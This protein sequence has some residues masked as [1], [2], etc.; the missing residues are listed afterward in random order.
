MKADYTFPKEKKK[1]FM[2]QEISALT[3]MSF[4]VTGRKLC[5]STGFC[6]FVIN[7]STT[8]PGTQQNMEFCSNE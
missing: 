3:A 5:S 6:S 1:G 7:N 8:L 2:H 4:Q